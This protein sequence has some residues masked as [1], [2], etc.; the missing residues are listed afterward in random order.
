MLPNPSL[1]FKPRSSN[2]G[3]PLV[4]GGHPEGTSSL[5]TT[6]WCAAP[7]NYLVPILDTRLGSSW[8]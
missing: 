3:I 2:A 6:L 5:V 4:H 8:L 7:Q 1:R